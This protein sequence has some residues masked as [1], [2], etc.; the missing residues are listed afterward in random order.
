M[1]SQP[2]TRAGQQHGRHSSQPAHRAAEPEAGGPHAG[3]EELA[4]VEIYG[5]EVCCGCELASQGE[6][7]PQVG[8]GGRT[9]RAEYQHQGAD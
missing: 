2:A 5:V 7:D 3:R 6:N 9:E 4:G 1:G 8:G